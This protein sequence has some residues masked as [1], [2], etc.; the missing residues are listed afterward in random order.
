MEREPHLTLQKV[1]YGLV[2]GILQ[3]FMTY[4][5]RDI[6]YTLFIGFHVSVLS[7][8]GCENEDPARR[9]DAPLNQGFTAGR[10][11]NSND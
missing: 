10:E 1:K 9:T 5:E 6:F 4:K 3:V 8:I 2:I 7:G 11:K